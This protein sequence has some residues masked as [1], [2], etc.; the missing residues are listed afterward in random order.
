MDTVDIMIFVL[1]LGGVIGLVNKVGAFNAG[2]GALSRIT[3]GKEFALVVLVFLLTTL[4][5]TETSKYPEEKKSTE[6]LLVAASESGRAC[7]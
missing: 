5:G 6:I 2:M 4:G 3:K 1:I 7:K